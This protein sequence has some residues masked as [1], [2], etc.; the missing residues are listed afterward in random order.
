MMK[1]TG[2]EADGPP[3]DLIDARIAASGADATAGADTAPF[4]ACF[5]QAA[6]ETSRTVANVARTI[7][8]NMGI[9]QQMSGR[10]REL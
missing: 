3:S 4:S 9:P 6:T 10:G 2:D 1:A 8:L 5:S 7:G